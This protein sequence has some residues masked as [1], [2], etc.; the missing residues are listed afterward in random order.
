MEKSAEFT[1]GLQKMA[2]DAQAKAKSAY[3]KGTALFGDYTEFAKGNVEALVESGKI[4]AVG[5]Q[6]IGSDWVEEGK[7]AFE[8]AT[9]DVKQMTSVK[10]PTEFFKLHTD[11]L[12]RNFESAI[13][14]SSKNG[15]AFAK[16]ASASFAPISGRISLATEKLKQAA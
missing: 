9:S 11:I 10:S 6:K 14:L 7:A 15:E 3:D 8:T 12:R 13:A 1:E 4:L 2:A 5:A 16:L